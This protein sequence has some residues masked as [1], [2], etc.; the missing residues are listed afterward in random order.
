[1]GK[2]LIGTCGYDYADWKEIFY[3]PYLKHDDYLSY[4]A[5]VFN[6]LELDFSYYTIPKASRL[7]E[8]VKKTGGKVAFSVKGNQAFT[9][10]I[11][12]A[13][14]KDA[15]K[16]FRQA[17]YP[18]V[19]NNVLSSVLLQFPEAFHYEKDTRIFLDSLI[20][21]FSDTPLV[22]EFRHNSWQQ[23]GVYEGLNKRGVGLCLVDMP[24]LSRLPNF[25]PV[26]TAGSA[27]MRFHG[28]NAKDWYTGDNKTRYN[29]LYTNNEL[30][31]YKSILLDI[32]QRAEITQ[33]FFNNHAEGNAVENAKEMQ[34]LMSE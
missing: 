6:A 25:T 9:H 13:K 10:R 11:E 16:D 12:P 1:M 26:V 33:I 20:K 15:V 7:D 27:Y 3:P 19:N 5:E 2:L 30:A 31:K 28:R 8:M 23:Q 29:Y 34:S 22:V 18:L 4:Y 17:L 24:E 21:E 32:M 14:W